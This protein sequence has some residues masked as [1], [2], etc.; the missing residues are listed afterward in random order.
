M[1]K[2]FCSQVVKERDDVVQKLDS[3]KFEKDNAERGWSDTMKYW[4]GKILGVAV[5]DLKRIAL[6]QQELYFALLKNMPNNKQ[7]TYKDE[8]TQKRNAAILRGSRRFLLYLSM[9]RKEQRLFET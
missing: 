2:L 3:A 4:G 6:E 7:L 9:L 8:I 1:G 5:E